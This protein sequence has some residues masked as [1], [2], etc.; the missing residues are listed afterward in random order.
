M[1][2]KNIKEVF[3]YHVTAKA[4]KAFATKLIIF[5]QSFISRSDSHS[6][7]FSSPYVGVYPVRFMTSDAMHLLE[8]IL[9]IDDPRQC[10]EDIYGLDEFDR[11]WH[12]APDV[13]NQAFLYA[14]HMLMNAPIDRKLAEQA[15]VHTIAMA[16]A[17]HLCSQ[18]TRRFKF[19]ADIQIAAML[20][21]TLD[22]KTDLKRLGTW[23]N[24]LLDRGE[25]FIDPKRGIHEKY[26]RAYQPDKRVIYAANDI[27]D[28]IVDVLNLLTE[29]FHDIKDSQG[30]V[31]STTAITTIDG[32]Q[33]LRDYSRRETKLVRDMMDIIRDPR[34]FIRQE[35]L[36]FTLDVMSTAK[37]N[38]LREN[39]NYLSDN[40]FAKDAPYEKMIT[41]LILFVM[42]EARQSQLDL[43]NMVMV[44]KRIN[45]IFR[46]SQTKKR[47]VIE[48]K[49]QFNELTNEANPRA[50]DSI[51][52][53]TS[54]ATV[55]YIVVRM[56]SINYYK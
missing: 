25:Q 1:V 32:E 7:F 4:D 45:S 17:K 21:E 39:L 13:T 56:L 47:E 12:V 6:L 3:D 16:I 55:I 41:N 20:Y 8:E 26:I 35:V 19:N 52:V 42:Q 44:I 36:D 23:N 18:I 22:N 28:R 9:Q 15:M 49:N 2:F 34:D 14:V 5:Y 11:S 31:L 48:L 54:I 40:L 30:R 53:S 46:S 43:D 27:Q 37:E 24:L 33:V 29:K 10:Q 38:V 51:K 50:R